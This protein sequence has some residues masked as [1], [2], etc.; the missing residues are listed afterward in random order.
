MENNLSQKS[1]ISIDLEQW[2]PK[3]TDYHVF[4]LKEVLFQG[5][6]LKET[7]FRKAMDDHDWESYRGKPTLIFCSNTAIIPQWAYLILS[8]HL[9]TVHSPAFLK[10]GNYKE[11]LLLEKIRNFDL[12]IYENKRLLIK[13]CSK[14]KMSQMPY[15][16]LCQ[17]LYAVAKAIS[18]GE[19]CST[20]PI[21]KHI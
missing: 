4:D 8:C 6:I 17:R 3:D 11:Q 18:F 5:M 15:M 10:E 13:G 2:I 20:V 9:A 21:Y 12:S 7:D 16:I 1:I 19:S 14:E